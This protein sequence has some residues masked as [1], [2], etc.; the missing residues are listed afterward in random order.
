MGKRKFTIEQR[1]LIR[2]IVKNRLKEGFEPKEIVQEL[3][4]DFKLKNINYKDVYDAK[5]WVSSN[6]N[7]KVNKCEDDA[8]C[9]LPEIPK[10]EEEEE[11]EAAPAEEHSTMI[12]KMILTREYLTDEH[13]VL[14]IR[15][16]LEV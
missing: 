5:Q 7:R 11:E 14:L 16:W 15:D 10:E 13:K 8:P 2:K 9:D 3:K 4:K 12:V 6:T 1:M